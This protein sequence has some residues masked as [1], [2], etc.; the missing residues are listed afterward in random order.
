M[1]QE[2]SHNRRLSLPFPLLAWKPRNQEPVYLC[3]SADQQRG[4]QEGDKEEQKGG[5]R[6]ALEGRHVYLVTR[7]K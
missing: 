7:F 5:S 3:L 1:Q 2:E 6:E 4:S